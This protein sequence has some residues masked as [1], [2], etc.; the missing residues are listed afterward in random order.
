MPEHGL[1]GFDQSLKSICGTVSLH[2]ATNWGEVCVS[3]GLVGR[4]ACAQQSQLSTEGLAEILLGTSCSRASGVHSMTH[5]HA[6]TS[7]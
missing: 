6:Y 1:V 5:L 2:H 4:S 3:E 7:H